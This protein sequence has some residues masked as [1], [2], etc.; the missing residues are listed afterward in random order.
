MMNAK[1]RALTKIR[2]FFATKREISLGAENVHVPKM[3]MKNAKALVLAKLLRTNTVSR[4]I[5]PIL[6]MR[7][8]QVTRPNVK[9]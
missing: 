5:D 8:K 2:L 4:D 7:K 9:Y 3:C 6:G 1:A